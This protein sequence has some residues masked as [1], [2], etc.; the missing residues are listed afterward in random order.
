[1]ILTG[2]AIAMIASPTVAADL[3]RPP[4][5]YKAP[6]PP[7]PPVFTWTGFYLGG[8]LGAAW[9]QHDITD[10]LYGLTWG[11]GSSNAAFIGGGQAGFN[12]QFGG[13]VLG[14]EGDFDWAA[15]SHNSG[16]IVVTGVGTGDLIQ[17]TSNNRWIGTLAARFG[18][19]FNN[20][21]LYGKAGG[22]WVGNNGFTVTDVT[23]G[24]SITRFNNN[25]RSGWLAGAGI[26]WAFAHNWTVK[27]EYDYVGLGSRTVVVP[28]G[29]PFLIGDTFP[30]GRN[31]QEAKVGI[32]Y[33]FNWGAGPG[34][35]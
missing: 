35:Y 9:A 22:G 3:S 11:S 14:V 31:V 10:T 33:L 27:F 26:E 5:T 17:I 29:A 7:P 8:N 25:T 28:A 23:T 6:P 18:V 32:N 19:A 1:M 15:N 4:P 2:M 34:P 24:T 16:A 20:V 13:F 12:Y 30:L 21:L